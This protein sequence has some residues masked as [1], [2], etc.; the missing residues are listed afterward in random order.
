VKGGR[1]VHASPYMKGYEHLLRMREGCES[2]EELSA[3]RFR[4]NYRRK[5]VIRPVKS[6]G[7]SFCNTLSVMSALRTPMTVRSSPAWIGRQV[8]TSST[9]A[10]RR[11]CRSCARVSGDV[12]EAPPFLVQLLLARAKIGRKMLPAK[13]FSRYTGCPTL[14]IRLRGMDGCTES[15]TCIVQR[16]VRQVTGGVSRAE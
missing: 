13:T 3:R 8:N 10:I 6:Q 1:R 9:S 5:A 16:A 7:S 11:R 2:S 12:E 4:P 14:Q 15:R